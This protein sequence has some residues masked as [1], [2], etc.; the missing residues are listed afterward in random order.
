MNEHHQNKR[1]WLNPDVFIEDP[2]DITPRD[3]EYEK[4]LAKKKAWGRV[5]KKA[6]SDD[7]RHFK[8]NSSDM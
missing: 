7:C 4:A 1:E 8:I 3:I 2:I 5:I 6:M